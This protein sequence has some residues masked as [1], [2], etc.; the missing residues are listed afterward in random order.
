MLWEPAELG[1]E[2]FSLAGGALI[3]SEVF[4]VEGFRHFHIYVTRDPN[5]NLD[6]RVFPIRPSVQDGPP[7]SASGAFRF[8]IA[9]W[10]GAQLSGVFYFGEQ[11]L[12]TAS[13]NLTFRFSPLMR[14]T[15][16][17]TTASVMNV[18]NVW[19]HAQD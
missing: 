12:L 2:N 6:I 3:D 17:N 9:S 13:G 1:L 15:L 5:R 11:T 14:L 10:T 4:Y 7:P 19:L 8:T 16:A 18:G